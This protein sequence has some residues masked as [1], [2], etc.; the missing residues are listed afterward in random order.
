M[1]HGL[2]GESESETL[3]AYHDCYNSEVTCCHDRRSP[4]MYVHTYIYR[5]LHLKLQPVSGGGG[6][7]IYLILIFSF[8]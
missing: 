3:L 7:M 1:V 4:P 5:P 2:M 6:G 8:P